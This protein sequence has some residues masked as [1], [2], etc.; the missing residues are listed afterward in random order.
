MTSDQLGALWGLKPISDT[1][2]PREVKNLKWPECRPAGLQDCY[3][4]PCI[5]EPVESLQLVLPQLASRQEGRLLLQLQGGT[6]STLDSSVAR[7][8]SATRC[9]LHTHTHKDNHSHM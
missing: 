7:G 3:L 4:E 1:E 5:C 9:F 8:I 6:S 2:A